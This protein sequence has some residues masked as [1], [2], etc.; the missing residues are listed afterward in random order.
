MRWHLELSQ[1]TYEIIYRPGKE[2]ITADAL[3]RACVIMGCI[4]SKQDL[5]KYHQDLCHSGITRFF[6]WTKAHNL[7]YSVDDIR[8]V[9]MECKICSELKPRFN[10]FKGKLI[11][12][13]RPFERINIDFKGPLP[14][15]T[16]NK[17]IL[18]IVDE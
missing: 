10:S 8:D 17:Y 11:K 7:P 16:R 3:S 5:I 15:S 1:Y 13:T 9:C 18:T 4:T 14:S 2:N 6:H 12:A